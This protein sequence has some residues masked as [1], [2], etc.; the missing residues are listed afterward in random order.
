[1]NSV[2]DGGDAR[3]IVTH[4]PKVHAHGILGVLEVDRWQ[5][6]QTRQLVPFVSGFDAVV[7]VDSVYIPY[8]LVRFEMMHK[9]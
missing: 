6:H 4:L 1:M 8:V 3:E 2:S 9:S 5:S 7:E